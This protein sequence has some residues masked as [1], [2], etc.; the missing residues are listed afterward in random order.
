MVIDIDLNHYIYTSLPDSLDI[1]TKPEE[2]NKVLF[3]LMKENK[4]YTASQIAKAC[5]FNPLKTAPK[6]RKIIT[7]LI[8]CQAAPIIAT[9]KGFKFAKSRDEIIEYHESLMRRHKGLLRRMYAV[10][11]IITHLPKDYKGH[12]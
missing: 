8:E 10:E 9:H 11:H 4:F 6:T 5:G 12:I 3:F 2:R 7:E 1:K